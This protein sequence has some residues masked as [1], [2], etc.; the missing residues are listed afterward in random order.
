[1]QITVKDESRQEYL[2]LD[3]QGTIEFDG[4]EVRDIGRLEWKNEKTPVLH[5]GHHKISGSVA[6]LAKPFA[7]LKKVVEKN[8]DGTKTTSY[9]IVSVINKKCTFKSRPEHI[10]SNQF[11]GLNSFTKMAR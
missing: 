8:A 6:P 2:L 10:L 4:E 5:I 1:M 3:L 11:I 7:V 9:S